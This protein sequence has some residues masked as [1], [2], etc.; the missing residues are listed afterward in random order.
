MLA[1]EEL[2]QLHRRQ[3]LDIQVCVEINDTQDLAIWYTPS[4]ALPCLEIQ[5]DPSL[6]YDYTWKKNTIAIISDGTAVL[7]L[8]NI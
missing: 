8:G 5:K 4:V 3:K 7:G 2:L 6:A 1:Q